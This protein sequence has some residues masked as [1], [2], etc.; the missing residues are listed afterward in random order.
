MEDP[1]PLHIPK[2]YSLTVLEDLFLSPQDPV[3]SDLLLSFSVLLFL[4]L[5]LV[6][7]THILGSQ[8]YLVIA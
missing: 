8:R 1:G 3:P 4:F 5:V 2:F 7:C 6:L